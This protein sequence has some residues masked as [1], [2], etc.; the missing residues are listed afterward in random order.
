MIEEVGTLS[1]SPTGV[2][3]RLPPQCLPTCTVS[4]IWPPRGL[5]LA[6]TGRSSPGPPLH[7]PRGSHPQPLVA[8]NHSLRLQYFRIQDG[9]RLKHAGFKM[10]KDVWSNWDVCSGRHCLDSPP[11]ALFSVCKCVH[12]GVTH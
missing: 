12:R 5:C 3:G 2:E 11:T 7:M 6:P 9:R 1:V 4:L 8:A 10:A